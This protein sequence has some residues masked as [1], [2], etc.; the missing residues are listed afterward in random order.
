MSRRRPPRLL[1]IGGAIVAGLVLGVGLDIARIGGVDAW[2]AGGDSHPGPTYDARGRTV[3][4]DGRAVYLDCRGSGSPT[5]VLEAGYGG[6]A[7]GWGTLIDGL[8]AVSRTC[9]WDRPG[10]G[11]STPRGLH[12]AGQA[13]DDLRAALAAAGEHGPFVAVAHS[14]GGIYARLFASGPGDPVAGLVML[15]TYEPDLGMATDPA[16]DPAFRREIQQ[17][18][19]DGAAIFLAGEDLDWPATLAELA[20]RS[21]P[22]TRPPTLLLYVDPHAR[23]HDADA[24]RLEGK[25]D[26]WWRAIRARYPEGEVEIV[27][28]AGHFIHL[29]Q[30]QLVIDRVRAMVLRFR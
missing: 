17:S 26:A 12:S 22:G 9:A 1:L 10:I 6:G 14:L 5:I 20:S 16:L 21:A 19:D 3:A 24:T 8:A 2:L 29:D 23:Y 4:V 7:D 27:P 25:I 15:D 28:N 11:R 18:L 30:P 13:V